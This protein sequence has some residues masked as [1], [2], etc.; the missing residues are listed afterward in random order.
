MNEYKIMNEWMNKTCWHEWMNEWIKNN[1]WMNEYKI[2]NEWM[3]I[4]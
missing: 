2:M 3:N 4:K 1:D